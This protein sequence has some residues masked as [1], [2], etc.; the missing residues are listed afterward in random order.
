MLG[1]SLVAGRA[2]KECMQRFPRKG[3]SV[4]DVDIDIVAVIEPIV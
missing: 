4:V 2:L 3:F 1:M